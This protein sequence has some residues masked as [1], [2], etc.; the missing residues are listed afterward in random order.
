[1]WLRLA[2]SVAAHLEQDVLLIDEVL[3]VGDAAFQKKCLGK[4]DEATKS[5]RAVLFVSHNLGIIGRLCDRALYFDHGRL[6]FAGGAAE[7]IAHYTAQLSETGAEVSFAPEPD[8]PAQI[9]AIRVLDAAGKASAELDRE[10]PFHVQIEYDVAQALVESHLTM[11][12]AQIDGVPVCT[13]TDADLTGEAPARTPGRYVATVVFPG[14]L[15]NVGPYTV[16]CGIGRRGQGAHDLRDGPT[17]TLHDYGS[18]AATGDEWGSQ[19]PGVLALPLSWKT[20][21]R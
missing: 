20:E 1:M 16:A 15:L 2:F 4:L 18:F 6:A 5:G 8:R 13:S 11:R 21:P 19:R 3:A 12:L 9:V 10:Q 7:T 17:L 14:G